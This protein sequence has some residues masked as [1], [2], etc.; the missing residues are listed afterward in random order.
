[1]TESI[2]PEAFLAA[3]PEATR[4]G[5]A[6]FRA[7]VRRAIP[8]VS[9]RVRLG[10]RIIGYDV[11]HRRRG[12][13]FAWIMP[14]VEHVHLGFTYGV[15][16]HDPDR[17]LEG[18]VTRARWV[19]LVPGQRL[20]DAPRVEALVREAARVALLPRQVRLASLLDREMLGTS[21]R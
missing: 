8:T 1:M 19:T 11:P 5:A 16:M 18:D 14:Q 6:V 9:E 3:Y 17:L 21:R 13:Y 7:L 2:P 15:L 20:A 4:E 12:V 10:W